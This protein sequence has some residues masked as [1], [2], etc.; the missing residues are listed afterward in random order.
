MSDIDAE[1]TQRFRAQATWALRALSVIMLGLGG[2]L[3]LKRIAF[4]LIAGDGQ[5]AFT[6]WTGVGEGHSAS[7]GAALV[8][9]GALLGAGSRRIARW[10][11]ALPEAGCP[12]C[13]YPRSPEDEICPECGLR[14]RSKQRPP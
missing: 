1:V 9:V 3:L 8:L 12:A 13:G 7:R 6:T 4:A 11:I 14:R 10:M 2:Y 5:A